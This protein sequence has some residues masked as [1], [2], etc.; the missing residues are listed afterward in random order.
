MS[1]VVQQKAAVS[2]LMLCSIACKV[3]V[4]LPLYVSISRLQFA[5]LMLAHKYRQ[6]VNHVIIHVCIAL[7][8][9]GDYS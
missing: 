2:P 5:F 4:Q 9:T 3:S 8:L 7:T 1:S 6:T